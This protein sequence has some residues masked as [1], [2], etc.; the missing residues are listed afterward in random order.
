MGR[1]AEAGEKGA[2]MDK[3]R[4]SA[5]THPGGPHL[6]GAAKMAQSVQRGYLS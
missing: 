6:T 4:R 3:D 5:W 1:W 2:R